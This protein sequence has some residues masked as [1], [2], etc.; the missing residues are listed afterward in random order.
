MKS[1]NAV[2]TKADSK[3]LNSDWGHLEP[4]RQCDEYGPID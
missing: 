3:D 2:P 4:L 1:M